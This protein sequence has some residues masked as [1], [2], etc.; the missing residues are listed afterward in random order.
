MREAVGPLGKC[1]LWS[2]TAP[3]VCREAV[4]MPLRFRGSDKLRGGLQDGQHW[5]SGVHK[6]Q[7]KCICM[8][9]TERVDGIL[10]CFLL[11]CA[12]IL[13]LVAAVLMF[14]GWEVYKY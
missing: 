6:E 2:S 12:S 3:H 13:G 1:T 4:L 8:L 10:Y 11:P 9:C 14:F 7:N 5:H